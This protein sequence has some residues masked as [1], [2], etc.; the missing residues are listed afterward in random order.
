MGLEIKQA[1]SWTPTKYTTEESVTTP[2]GLIIKSGRKQST[3]DDE[4]TFT[5]GTAFPVACI[6]VVITRE[7]PE[8]T[9]PL[10]PSEPPSR[11]EF[12]IKRDVGL[13]N[14]YFGW[15]AIGY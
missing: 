4:Q 14:C 13:N 10:G 9:S 2:N 15:I 3:T 11:T 5:F 12:K 6:C 7:D 1:L 8:Q